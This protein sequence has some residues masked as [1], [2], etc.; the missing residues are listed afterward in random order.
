MT[1]H[2]RRSWVT[3]KNK[4]YKARSYN[5][6]EGEPILIDANVWLFLHPPPGDSGSGWSK[7]YTDAYARLLA[8]KARVLTDALVLSEYLNRYFRIEF[9]AG[10]REEFRSFKAFRKSD[11]FTQVASDAIAEVREIT[12]KAELCDTCLKSLCFDDV[13]A[14]AESGSLDFNDAVLVDSCRHHGWKLLTNDEDCSTGG[15]EVITSLPAL[16]RACS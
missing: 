9:E 11:R 4:A 16:L 10:W 1:P 5:F 12:K 3:K 13:L 7:D 14:G 15:I 2:G 8:A 6:Q